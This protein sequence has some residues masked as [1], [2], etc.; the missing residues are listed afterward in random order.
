MIRS[1]DT[2][3]LTINSEIMKSQYICHNF[4]KEIVPFLVCIYTGQHKTSTHSYMCVYPD[5]Y[6]I[7]VL[8][9]SKT[10][11]CVRRANYKILKVCILSYAYIEGMITGIPTDITRNKIVQ[12]IAYYLSGFLY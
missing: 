1:Y 5:R 8:E 12:I 10:V 9:L 7:P 4:G 11:G 2:L 6:S 3:E